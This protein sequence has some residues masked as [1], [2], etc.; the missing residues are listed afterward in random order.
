MTYLLDT[1]Y[2]IWAITDTK[3]ISK[4][5]KE[6]ISNPE[7]RIVISTISF[8][9]VALKSSIGKL[10]ITGY[11]PEDFPDACLQVGFDIECLSAK[12]SS[13]Y[14]QLKATYHRD[15][16]DRML[17]W[18]AIRNNYTLISIDKNVKKYKSEG[19]KVWD[20]Q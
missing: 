7:N 8:W 15:P 3:K 4:A 18:Q 1:H 12:D 20:T 9:E 16:F 6:V 5:I 13:T 19:L 17:I 11:S 2:M 14:H 10:E